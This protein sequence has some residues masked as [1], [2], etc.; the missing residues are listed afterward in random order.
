MTLNQGVCGQNPVIRINF[1]LASCLLVLRTRRSDEVAH[2]AGTYTLA[3]NRP[4]PQ[5]KIYFLLA[6]CL[7]AQRRLMRLSAK[8]NH[9]EIAL[10]PRYIKNLLSTWCA[11]TLAPR[12]R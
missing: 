7:L 11:H 8:T 2:R 12:S 1:V 9:V 4:K 6:K 3:T 10:D 5:F